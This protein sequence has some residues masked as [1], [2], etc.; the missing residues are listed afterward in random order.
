MI[1][2]NSIIKHSLMYNPEGKEQWKHMK[3]NMKE[4]EN[5]TKAGIK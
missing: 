4:A 1:I 2:E 3:Y 5:D